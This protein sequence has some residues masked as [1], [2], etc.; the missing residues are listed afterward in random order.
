[1]RATFCWSCYIFC[2]FLQ[3]CAPCILLLLVAG[4]FWFY[5]VPGHLLEISFLFSQRWYYSSR[6][7]FLFYPQTLEFSV[8][9][10]CHLSLLSPAPLELCTRSQPQS[11]KR[12]EFGIQGIGG[13]CR[14]LQGIFWVRFSQWLIAD[15]LLASRTHWQELC[16]FDNIWYLPLFWSPPSPQ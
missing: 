9:A 10:P 7:W 15:F 11:Q 12:Y 2:G 1:M 3:P 6:F 13:A 16:P 8:S 4:F 14:L 5:S